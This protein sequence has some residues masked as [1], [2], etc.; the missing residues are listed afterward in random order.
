MLECLG[1][2]SFRQSFTK[3]KLLANNIFLRRLD[4]DGSLIN[5]LEGSQLAELK[6]LTHLS[7]KSIVLDMKIAYCSQIYS[8]TG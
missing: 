6:G 3:M 2:R 1:L 8:W 4:L 5:D 7:I